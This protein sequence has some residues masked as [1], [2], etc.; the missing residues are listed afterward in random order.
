VRC[1]GLTSGAYRCTHVIRLYVVHRHSHT[2]KEECCCFTGS[3]FAADAVKEHSAERIG[4]CANSEI[5][6]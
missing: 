2:S 1:F 3:I 4:K 5:C 6:R